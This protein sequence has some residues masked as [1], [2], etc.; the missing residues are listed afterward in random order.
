MACKSQELV[1]TFHNKTLGEKLPEKI[2]L[3]TIR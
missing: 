2:L 1:Q 3:K